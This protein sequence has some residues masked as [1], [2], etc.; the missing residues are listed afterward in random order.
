MS[1]IKSTR[2]FTI[3][4]GTYTTGGVVY[5]TLGSASVISSTNDDV[6]IY[7]PDGPAAR[8][9]FAHFPTPFNPHKSFLRWTTT[10]H[11]AGTKQNFKVRIYGTNG[12]PPSSST[13]FT[14]IQLTHYGNW[15]KASFSG[16]TYNN[17]PEISVELVEFF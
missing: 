15:P 5:W 14:Q 11:S 2:R 12:Y 16:E 10:A 8:F 4:M 9:C 3:S 6:R 13:I 17:A 1:A 7:S